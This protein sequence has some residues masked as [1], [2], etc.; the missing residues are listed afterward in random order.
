MKNIIYILIVLIASCSREDHLKQFKPKNQLSFSSSSG[1]YNASSGILTDTIKVSKS[2]IYNKDISLS[3]TDGI[4]SIRITNEIGTLINEQLIEAGKLTYKL[5]VPG[6]IAGNTTYR[7]QLVE[8]SGNIQTISL[9]LYGFNNW[10]P[11]ATFTKDDANKRLDFT[12]SIDQD[13]R[14]GGRVFEYRV[15]VNGNLRKQDET[16]YFVTTTNNGF[17]IGNS[18]LVKLE[19]IDNDGAVSAFV[20]QNVTIN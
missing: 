1:F 11:L 12:Q 9:N 2:A 20:E 7:I 16:P 13:R 10:L 18:Y 19:V 4:K 14:F 17:T 6:I 3:N 8:V 15:Y 5:T